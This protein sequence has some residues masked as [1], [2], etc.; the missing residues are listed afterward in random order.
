MPSNT[1]TPLKPDEFEDHRRFSRKRRRSVSECVDISPENYIIPDHMMSTSSTTSLLHS[2][3]KPKT[4]IKSHLTPIKQL[5]FSPSQ[6]LN[7][8]LLSF[9][10]NLS[11][12]PEK[13]NRPGGSEE[14]ASPGPLVTP[15]PLGV[16]RLSQGDDCTTPKST[17][18]FLNRLNKSDAR[19]PTPFKNALA[20][21]EKKVGTKMSL[22]PS[23]IAEDIADLIKKEQECDS[24]FDSSE[25]PAAS[26]NGESSST[27][28]PPNEQDL[29]RYLLH[30]SVPRRFQSPAAPYRS[31]VRKALASAWGTPGT[32][33]STPGTGV[34]GL[35]VL[36]PAAGDNG[37]SFL[38]DTQDSGVVFDTPSKLLG[39]ESSFFSPSSL[40][41]NSLSEELDPPLPLSSGTGLVSSTPLAVM[42]GK[43][44]A[45]SNITTT[46]T[47]ITTTTRAQHNVSS[48]PPSASRLLSSSSL[49]YL[50]NQ[51]D[52][53]FDEVI[54]IIVPLATIGNP[55][56]TIFKLDPRFWVVATG[57]SLDQ[58]EMTDM[59][60]SYLNELE[61]SKSRVVRSLCL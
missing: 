33:G 34:G 26:L 58:Q 22:S 25:S 40:V 48:P 37:R 31:R 18:G 30:A 23:R 38:G 44:V 3:F 39:D 29:A 7:S 46:T 15:T 12:T 60:R 28:Y 53:S 32:P 27:R 59:A 57:K 9:N 52:D 10:V 55:D 19:T 45:A 6:F 4:P 47:S 42:N 13:Q 49:L 35:A 50:N 16:S 5:P 51:S 36:S 17:N 1:S 14:G 61:R 54:K 56:R 43:S 20:E 41:Q 21:I 8:P 11:S 24:L 2:T